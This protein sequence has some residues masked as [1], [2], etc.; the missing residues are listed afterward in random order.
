LNPSRKKKTPWY[1]TDLTKRHA[2]FDI[3]HAAALWGKS[4]DVNQQDTGG[5]SLWLLVRLDEIL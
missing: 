1:A 4:A 2:T 3:I 5:D